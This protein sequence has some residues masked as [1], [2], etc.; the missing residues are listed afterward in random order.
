MLTFMFKTAYSDLT[1]I[2]V[3][4]QFGSQH[5][6]HHEIKDTALANQT[7]FA[8]ILCGLH[9]IEFGCTAEWN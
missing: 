1:T 4:V 5:Q 6:G 3:A 7:E 2:A 9:S 8:L